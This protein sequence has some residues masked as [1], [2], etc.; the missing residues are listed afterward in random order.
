M[1]RAIWLMAALTSSRPPVRKPCAVHTGS[2]LSWQSSRQVSALA[3]A[4]SEHDQTDVWMD[5]ICRHAPLSETA[6]VGDAV[7][8]GSVVDDRQPVTTVCTQSDEVQLDTVTSAV[9]AR[10]GADVTGEW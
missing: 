5:C 1:A 2:S 10:E 6:S 4:L 9:G 7:T 8:G 3:P